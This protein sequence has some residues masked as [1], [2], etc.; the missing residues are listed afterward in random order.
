MSDCNP[1]QFSFND[2]ETPGIEISFGGIC[3][4]FRSLLPDFSTTASTPTSVADS[5]SRSPTST[6]LDESAFV[7][8]MSRGGFRK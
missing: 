2:E 5:S 3:N 1:Y 6:G 7:T 8:A 4:F